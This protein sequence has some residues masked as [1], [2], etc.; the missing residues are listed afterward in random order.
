MQRNIKL[1]RKRKAWKA[2]MAGW[3]TWVGGA[4]EKGSGI[5]APSH[6]FLIH[7]PGCSKAG[8]LKGKSI[9]RILRGEGKWQGAKGSGANHG[10]CRLWDV[11]VN[12]GETWAGG[13]KWPTSMGRSEGQ[14][15]HCYPLPRR[16]LHMQQRSNNFWYLLLAVRTN[17]F[18]HLM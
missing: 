3:G 8:G 5:S 17:Q 13:S 14:A 2:L 18:S 15:F 10:W 12:Q 16:S 11:W 1:G 4:T 9:G 7:V 6:G